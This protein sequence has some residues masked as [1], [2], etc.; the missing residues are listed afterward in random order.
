MWEWVKQRLCR[1][2]YQTFLVFSGGKKTHHDIRECIKCGKAETI[3]SGTQREWRVR[4]G[5]DWLYPGYSADKEMTI[6]E[7]QQ[8]IDTLHIEQYFRTS[9]ETDIW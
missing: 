1:H 4:H 7:R 5:Y 3:F 2:K 8:N 9:N 6:E